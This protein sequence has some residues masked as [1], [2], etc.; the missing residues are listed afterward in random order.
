M[1]LSKVSG[2][3]DKVR[4]LFWE[5]YAVISSI[6]FLNYKIEK[7]SSLGLYSDVL[8]TIFRLGENTVTE[9]QLLRPIATCLRHLGNFEL[10]LDFINTAIKVHTKNSTM[11]AEKAKILSHLDKKT[12]AI[13][14]YKMSLFYDPDNAENYFSLGK[15][16]EECSDL[17]R[18]KEAYEK[19]LTINQSHAPS[20][21]HLSQVYSSLG[22]HRKAI[23]ILKN[24]TNGSHLYAASKIFSARSHNKLGN[25]KAALEIL[26][27][28]I[29]DDCLATRAFEEKMYVT[30]QL[31]SYD[32][33]NE[34]SILN[35]S[36]AQLHPVLRI[37]KIIKNF[38][39][40]EFEAARDTLIGLD[41][42]N[43]NFKL[44]AK[45][46]KFISNYR[47]FLGRCLSLGPSSNGDNEKFMYHLGDSHSLS[48]AGHKL[49][50]GD[51]K[52]LIKPVTTVGGKA[53]HI[54]CNENNQYQEI[55]RRNLQA[56]P[57]ISSVF[58]SF[59]EIDCR[60]DEGNFK[61]TP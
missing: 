14:L 32:G 13:S 43:T 42:R 60:C 61:S 3:D 35:K 58:F 2:I 10:A 31:V 47:V 5:Q 28:L 6:D 29:A 15:L 52:M 18:A 53:W 30:Q 21:L 25:I 46:K 9:D 8:L 22:Y 51:V 38:R 44:D 40:L 16:Y 39:A 57:G 55:T 17:E 27:K 54:G 12:D 23:I 37:I 11:F 41:E 36:N 45:Q 4:I 49:Q 1:E 34:T 50:V 59:G 7:L 56:L 24:I 33:I 20:S 26:D 48:F 19:S